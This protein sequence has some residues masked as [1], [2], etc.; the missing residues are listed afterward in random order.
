MEF[1]V[2][3]VNLR[4]QIVHKKFKLAHQGKKWLYRFK[5]E[6]NCLKKLQDNYTPHPDVSHYP[7]PK[8]VSVDEDNYSLTTSYCGVNALNNNFTAKKRRVK[9][10]ILPVNL[11]STIECIIDNLNN[12]NI[13]HNDITNNNVCVDK[14]GNVSLIDFEM[15][16][17]EL[18]KIKTDDDVYEYVRTLVE[19]DV[20]SREDKEYVKAKLVKYDTMKALTKHYNKVSKETLD[21]LEKQIK[22]LRFVDVRDNPWS[23]LFMFN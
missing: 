23:M 17:Y 21:E 8:L 9:N 16:I 10:K 13:I 18:P 4:K 19:N 7:F 22:K 11:T 6:V 1:I 3:T 20:I 2:S 14:S 15:S 12:N 5:T